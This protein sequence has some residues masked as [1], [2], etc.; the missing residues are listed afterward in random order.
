MRALPSIQVRRGLRIVAG[1]ACVVAISSCGLGEGG[2]GAEDGRE[3]ACTDG[4]DND[5]DGLADCTDTDC[6]SARACSANGGETTCDDGRDDDDDGRADCDDVDCEG[7]AACDGSDGTDG[8]DTCDGPSADCTRAACADHPACRPAGPCDAE[9]LP[10]RLPIAIEGSTTGGRNRIAN[11][12]CVQDGGRNAP[13][14]L[15]TFVAPRAGVYAFTTEGSAFDT[16]LSLREGDCD[17]RELAC[18][19]DVGQDVKQSR[20]VAMLEADQRVLVVVD[21]FERQAGKFTLG[22]GQIENVCGDGRDDDGDGDTD[23]RDGDCAA[24][25]SCN[26][27]RCPAEDLG[28]RL[29]ATASGTTRGASGLGLASCGRGGGGAPEATFAWTAPAAGR[30]VFSTEGSAFDTILYVREGGCSGPELACADDVVEGRVRHS[31]VEVALAARQSVAIVVDGFDDESG[32]FTLRIGALEQRCDDRADDDG[33]GR[34]DCDDDDCTFSETCLQGGSWPG[35]WARLEDDMLGE[36]NARRRAGATCGPYEG[37]PARTFAAAPALTMHPLIRVAARL[38]SRDM[39][40]NNYFDHVARDGRTFSQRMSAAGY[41]GPFP[42]GENLSGGSAT[43]ADA[44][45]GLMSSPG[46][47]RN[48]MNPDY[49]VIGIGYY[50]VDTGFRH[51][52]TQNF[53]G[54]E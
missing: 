14:G 47:C 38:H 21:G 49:R 1:F 24:D 7:D 45:A 23:C 41:G 27:V 3:T 37:E 54:G 8:D 22:V 12:R 11:A 13:D 4:S 10:A 28:S 2:G 48:I 19:D 6:R 29:P 31:R 16:V 17:G 35:A 26:G 53:G 51:Y 36:V 25:P 5:G 42:W 32:A 46:H 30:Y 18:N 33:D 43:A 50:N 52:W 34:I 40:E 9:V 39:G 44:V 15:F 20:I